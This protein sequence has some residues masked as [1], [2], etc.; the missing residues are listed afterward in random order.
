[1]KKTLTSVVVNCCLLSMFHSAQADISL[2]NTVVSDYTL[3]GISQTQGNPALQVSLDWGGMDGLYAG[4]WTSRVD[5]G[6]ADKT[7]NEV[8]YYVGKYWQLNEKTGLD[9]GIAYY[10]YHGASFSDDYNYPEAHAKFSY[11]SSFGDSELNFWFTN[12]Y[13]N[14]GADNS[15]VVLAHKFKVAEGHNIRL[16]Y[17]HSTSH[18]EEKFAWGGSNNKSYDHYRVEYITNW[19]GLDINLAAEDTNDIADFYDADSRIVLS[20]GKTFN[21]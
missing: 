4:I 14:L 17:K 16:I 20:V 5:F 8:D 19:K 6:T 15:V 3:N 7:S 10:S 13:G 9:V 21:F 11:N 1:M 2:T 18:D 12:N